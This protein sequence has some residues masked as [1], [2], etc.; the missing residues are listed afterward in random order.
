MRGLR[1]ITGNRPVAKLRLASLAVT[2][3]LGSLAVIWVSLT[4]WDR[5]H[6]LHSEF[7]GL[8]AENFYLGARMRGDVQRLNDTLLRYRLRGDA[9]D[10]SSFTN[11]FVALGQWLDENRARARAR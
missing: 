10:Y 1:R 4:T 11:D 6:H 8:K 5:V 7:A 9:A 2:A 3:L